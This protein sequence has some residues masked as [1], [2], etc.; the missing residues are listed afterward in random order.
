MGSIRHNIWRLDSLYF[1]VRYKILVILLI[2]HVANGGGRKEDK[3]RKYD[4]GEKD[5]V[6]GEP[7]GQLTKLQTQCEVEGI[8]D[9]ECACRQLQL[10]R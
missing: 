7:Y 4:I 8:D 6:F 5:R 1:K 9:R 2:L 10:P 3:R